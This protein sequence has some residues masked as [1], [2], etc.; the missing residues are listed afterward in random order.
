MM[1][2]KS[3]LLSTAL[4][5]TASLF[6]SSTTTNAVEITGGISF[7]GGYTPDNNDL[8]AATKVT[9][10]PTVV[11]DSNGDFTLPMFTLVTM[12][13]YLEW[14]PSFTVSPAN[15]LWSV[16]GFTFDLTSLA[17]TAESANSITLNG[18]GVVKHANFDDTDGNW[19]AT[20]NT[21]GNTFSW[22]A[23]SSSVPD[24]GTSVALLGI[25]VVG[26]GLLR[27]RL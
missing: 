3:F 13:N 14:D 1:H 5:L 16:G 25:A 9:F 15:P 4:A 24:G 2:K 19:V 10:G 26:T 27:R 17:V 7:A 6:L 23:S 20:F 22:S 12:A 18:L 21:S 8:T 11:M